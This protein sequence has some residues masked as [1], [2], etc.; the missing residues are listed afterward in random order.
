MVNDPLVVLADEPTGNLDTA[1]T[2]RRA[3][4]LPGAACGWTDLRDRHA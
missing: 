1:A 4:D 3:E 2:P